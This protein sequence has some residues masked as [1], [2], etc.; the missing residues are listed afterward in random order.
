MPAIRSMVKT[1]LPIFLLCAIFVA[2]SI[3]ADSWD[4]K[5]VHGSVGQGMVAVFDAP[6][7][8]ALDTMTTPGHCAD[9]D[10]SYPYRL[11]VGL[12]SGLSSKRTTC[13]RF[14]SLF[15]GVVSLWLL[16]QLGQTLFDGRTGLLFAL[17]LVGSP[18]MVELLRA[19]GFMSLT[20]AV[21]AA[22][23]L[24]EARAIRQTAGPGEA[25][26]WSVAQAAL[27]LSTLSLYALGRLVV[28]VPVLGH[29]CRMRH[30]WRRTAVVSSRPR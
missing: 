21:V 24:L 2:L 4:T 5:R 13:L 7:T 22:I 12:A 25:L 30:A 15:F 6:L 19:Y 27:C 23:L 3:A 18:G 1:Q 11:A 17:L 29:L 9:I 20:T 14:V 26:G 8:P 10:R 16:H 28:V